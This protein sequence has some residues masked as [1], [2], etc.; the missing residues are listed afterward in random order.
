[1][2]L[3][4]NSEYFFIPGY[5]DYKNNKN[6]G[7]GLKNVN[8]FCILSQLSKTEFDGQPNSNEYDTWIQYL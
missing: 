2:L 6:Q 3:P 4:S 5:S 1:M 7:F 8:E